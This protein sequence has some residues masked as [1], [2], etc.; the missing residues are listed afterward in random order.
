MRRVDLM[1]VDYL[2]LKNRLP[3]SDLAA[4]DMACFKML[5]TTRM[6]PFMGDIGSSGFGGIFL[7]RFLRQW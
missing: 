5:E 4:L 7:G 6:A 1:V 3:S 2:P